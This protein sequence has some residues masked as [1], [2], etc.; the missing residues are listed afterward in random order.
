M[1][2]SQISRC[3]F[4]GLPVLGSGQRRDYTEAG[5]GHTR[6]CC[7]SLPE[8][9]SE[10]RQ[11]MKA[12]WRKSSDMDFTTSCTLLSIIGKLNRSGC[13]CLCFLFLATVPSPISTPTPAQQ[14]SKPSKPSNSSQPANKQKM[15]PPAGYPGYHPLAPLGSW[16]IAAEG[17]SDWVN[18]P[19]LGN[20]AFA[21]TR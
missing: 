11:K 18:H 13:L 8:V 17:P 16:L 4:S 14:P 10:G 3:T 5:L 21:P 7:S 6:M 20:L 15:E 19:I 2:S 9:K 1:W 12:S